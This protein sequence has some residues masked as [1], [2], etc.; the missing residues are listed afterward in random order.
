MV[1][2]EAVARKIRRRDLEISWDRPQSTWSTH[3]LPHRR[4]NRDKQDKK[5]SVRESHVLAKTTNGL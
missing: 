4:T 5:K 1:V 2:P 3:R